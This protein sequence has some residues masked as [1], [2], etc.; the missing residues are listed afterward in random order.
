MRDDELAYY[1][2][3]G[4][5]T[6]LDPGSDAIE[7]LPEA[8]LAL[9]PV[10]QGLILPAFWAAGQLSGRG[11]G[12]AALSIWR[13]QPRALRD[14]RLLGHLVRPQQRRARPRGAQQDGAAS[15][16]RLGPHDRG[17]GARGGTR[18][19]RHRQGGRR[20]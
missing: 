20:D 13:G 10:V 12:L 2:T 4:P 19:R 1:S 5:M 16:G 8:P 3:A 14:P 18:K 11:R 6:T 17:R 15:L 9:G 7:Q